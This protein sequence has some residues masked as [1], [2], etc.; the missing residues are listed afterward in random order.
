MKVLEYIENQTEL[1]MG[2]FEEVTKQALGFMEVQTPEAEGLVLYLKSK[3][4]GTYNFKYVRI[5]YRHGTEEFT[6]DFLV[7][8]I[9]FQG[10]SFK[11]AHLISEDD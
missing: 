4:P 9:L 11:I 7:F 10:K 5:Q 2:T 3:L 8:E 1:V 6:Q